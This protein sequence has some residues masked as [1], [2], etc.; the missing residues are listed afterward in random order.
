[1]SVAG[2]AFA[3]VLALTGVLAA[4][5]ARRAKSN[6]KPF[7]DIAAA[8]WAVF[9]VAEAASGYLGA[10][11]ADAIGL[12]ACAIAPTALSLGA[13]ARLMRE[14]PL[15]FAR[16]V[17][18]VSAIAGI[19]ASWWG[20]P[21]FAF[22]PLAANAIAL[23]VLG[24]AHFQ[25]NRREASLIAASACALAAGAPAFL[26]AGAQALLLFAAA[27]LMGI[28]LAVSPPSDIRVEQ[29]RWTSR[30]LAVRRKR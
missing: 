1:M 23:F 8:A 16:V 22:L 20:L 21:L 13:I 19:A 30:R 5:I 17:L 29:K 3:A 25:T 9:A 12:I 24:I 14:P 27:S 11:L 6:A 7:V 26:Q 4:L 10:T 2:L 18:I 28:A 15:W